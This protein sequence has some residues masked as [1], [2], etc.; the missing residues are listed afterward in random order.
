M[1]KNNAVLFDGLSSTSQNIELII[2]EKNNLLVF[3]SSAIGLIKWPIADVS[4][5]KSSDVLNIH[6]GS[7]PVQIV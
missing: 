2:D 5:Y 4:F 6:Y 1:L 7:I 3:S